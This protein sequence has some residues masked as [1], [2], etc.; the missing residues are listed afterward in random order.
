MSRRAL[1]STTPQ[2]QISL[3]RACPP[4]LNGYKNLLT[5]LCQNLLDRTASEA[6]KSGRRP[7]QLEV[8]VRDGYSSQHGGGSMTSNTM[9]WPVKVLKRGREE[10]SGDGEGGAGGGGGGGETAVGQLVSAAETWIEARIRSGAIKIGIATFKV[11][12]RYSQVDPSS[13]G[14]PSITSY[15]ASPAASGASAPGTSSGGP[16]ASLAVR[17]GSEDWDAPV[18]SGGGAGSAAKRKRGPA[19]GVFG[20]GSEAPMD[21][22]AADTAVQTPWDLDEAVRQ[23]ARVGRGSNAPGTTPNPDSC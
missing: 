3:Q 5:E 2:Q 12:A 9:K 6:E 8:A 7:H 21:F 22:E 18:R 15:F 1:T 19:A 13:A 10:I 23:Q 17:R 14:T 16:R 11:A 4:T 20:A